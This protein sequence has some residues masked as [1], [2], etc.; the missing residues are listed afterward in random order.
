MPRP[1][2]EGHHPAPPPGAS[3]IVGT[4][5][6]AGAPGHLIRRAQQV[7]I[8]IWGQL[9]DG[10]LTSPQFAVL[11]ALGRD[12]G[13]DQTR[14]SLLA[15]LDTSTCQ[16]VVSRLQERGLLERARDPQD[17]RRWLLALTPRGEATLARVLP[18]V[19]EVGERLL[20]PL[21]RQEGV[22]LRRLLAKVAVRGPAVSRVRGS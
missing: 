3:D 15:S 8:E 1:R 2:R 6:L 21:T 16:G 20:E 9:V 11:C 10:G 13:I 22:E 7:H 5:D 19:I 17:G 4:Y 12:R 18:A 14:L